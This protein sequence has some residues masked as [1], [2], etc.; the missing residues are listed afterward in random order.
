MTPAFG[1]QYSIQL[2]YWCNAGAIIPIYRVGVYCGDVWMIS[3]SA[4]SNPYASL[5]SMPLGGI[6]FFFPN[7]LL[8]FTPI[9]PRIRLRFQTLLVRCCARTGYIL[10]ANSVSPGR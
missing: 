3:H 9:A 7:S 1:G 8:S 10:C 4:L 6:L 5:K 2:S